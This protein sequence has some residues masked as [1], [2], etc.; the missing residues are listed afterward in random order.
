[1]QSEWE[2]VFRREGEP[3]EVVSMSADNLR[4]GDEFH[5]SG[6]H[7]VVTKDDGRSS[8]DGHAARLICEP[9]TSQ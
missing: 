6:I 7:W 4:P 3:D 9:A 8:L 1:M 5:R 2:L